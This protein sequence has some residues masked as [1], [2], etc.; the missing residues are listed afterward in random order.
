M[1]AARKSM[2]K[3]LIAGIL[4]VLSCMFLFVRPVHAKSLSKKKPKISSLSGFENG[5]VVLRYS[6]VKGAKKYQIYRSKKKNGKYKKFGTSTTTTFSKKANGLYYYKV[7]GVSGKKKGKFSKPVRIFAA[8]G[9]ITDLGFSGITG[10]TARV[11]VYNGTPKTMAFLGTNIGNFYLVDKYTGQVVSK[12]MAI[13]STT[14]DWISYGMGKM[15]GSNQ[16]QSLY[17]YSYGYSTWMKYQS[18]RNRYVLLLTASFYPGAKAKSN[19]AFS[20]AVGT[21]YALSSVAC[22]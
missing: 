15:I 14:G 7:R 8:T 9:V 12:D 2:M 3:W 5:Q 19:E 16:T 18:N 10:M 22:K 21:S 13:L 4:V 20:L 17:F 6:S 1:K 11:L